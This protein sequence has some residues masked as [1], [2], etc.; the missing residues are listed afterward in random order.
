MEAIQSSSE[1]PYSQI[2][3]RGPPYCTYSYPTFVSGF[4]CALVMLGYLG[5][6]EVGYV[7]FGDATMLWILLILF[8]C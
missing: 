2:H 8:L 3:L 7:G 5:L 6:V 4:S 1:L